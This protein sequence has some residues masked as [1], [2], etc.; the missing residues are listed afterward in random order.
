MNIQIS[1][2]SNDWPYLVVRKDFRDAPSVKMLGFLV[3]TSSAKVAFSL[4]IVFIMISITW[5]VG[6]DVVCV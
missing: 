6:W 2:N 4:V 3:A 5:G 1:L